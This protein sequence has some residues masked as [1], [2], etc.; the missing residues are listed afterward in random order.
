MDGCSLRWL[1]RGLTGLLITAVLATAVAVSPAAAEADGKSGLASS[2]DDGSVLPL[3]A[4]G[5]ALLGFLGPLPTG[6]AADDLAKAV[7]AAS[8]STERNPFGLLVRF[9]ESATAVEVAEVLGAVGGSLI[10][11]SLDGAGLYLVETLRD[12]DA[13]LVLLG[14]SPVVKWAGPDA[15]V[16][17]AD[18]PSDPRL[19]ELWGLT[20]ANGI[21]APG[22]W[23]HSLGDSS[24]VVAVIDTGVDLDHPDLEANIWTNPGE[25][26]GNGI[27]DDGNGYIDDLHGW[28]FVNDDADPN[29]DNNHGT[30]VAGTIAGVANDVG[31]VGVAPGV[32][33]MALKFLSASGGGY[34]SDAVSALAY[35]IANGASISNNSWGGGGSSGAM[36]GMIDQ[37]AAADHLFVAA[38]GNDGSDNDTWPTYPASYPQDIVLTVASTQIDGNRSSFSN[39]GEIGVD[40]AAPGSAILSSVFGGGYATFSG[41]SMATPHVVGVAALMR[42]V[43]PDLTA[44]QVKERLIDSSTW[45]DALSTVSGS[46]GRVDAAAAVGA[47]VAAAP[48]VSI[49][50]PVGAVAEG[51]P[52]TLVATAIGSDGADVSA[53]IA[54][55]DSAGT[56]LATG[57]IFQWTPQVAGVQRLRAAVTLA[58]LTGLDAV[59]IDVQEVQRGIT[60]VSPNGGETFA[61]GDEVEISWTSEGPVGGVDVSIERRAQVMGEYTGD[62]ALPILDHQTLDVELEVTD[63]GEVGTV[64]LGIRLNHTYDA[65]LQI[66]LVHPD[67]TTVSLASGVGSWRNDFGEGAADCSGTLTVF[68]DDADTAIDSG[69]APFAGRHRPTDA[70][71]AFAGKSALGTW[72]LRIHDQ[73]SWDQGELYCADLSISSAVATVATGVDPS[74]G[75]ATWIVPEGGIEGPLMASVVAGGLSDRSDAWF[76]AAAPPTTT[77]PPCSSPTTTTTSTSTTAPPESTTTSTTTSSSTTVPPESTTTSTTSTSTTAPPES[78]TTTS[79]T[80]T[81]TTAP[82]E[83]TTTTSTTTVPPC[84]T[85]TT[86][87]PPTTTTTAPPE[88]TSTTTTTTTT[89]STTTTTTLPTTTTTAPPSLEIK[90]PNGGE[91]FARGEQVLIDWSATNVGGDVE[92]LVRRAG[93]RE[94]ESP[95]AAALPI[96][97]F[98]TLVLS[99]EMVGEGPVTAIEVGLR[100]DHTYTADLEIRLVAPDGESVR[101]AFHNGGW[102]DDFGSGADDCSGTLTVFA[103]DAALSIEA[104]VAPFVGRHRP[105]ESMAALA[106]QSMAG[107]W[108]LEITDHWGWD[109]GSLYC[110]RLTVFGESTT[111]TDGVDAGIGSYVWT[112]PDGLVT[113]DFLVEV[114]GLLSDRSDGTFHIEG[115]APP[116]TTTTLPPTTTTTV[117][118]TTTTTVPPTTTLPPTTT[119]LPPTTTTTQP[120]TTDVVVSTGYTAEEF[121]GVANA[122]AIL[123]M[124]VA[125][126]QR[127]G[128]YVVSFLTAINPTPPEPLRPRPPVD[129]PQVLASV[130]TEEELPMLL[131]V[132][133]A[134]DLT[135]EEM[136]KFGAILLAFFVGLT[137]G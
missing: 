3:S 36:S 45:V 7:L 50:E 87:A 120:P 9:T 56:V 105:Y 112:S 134:W 96:E 135:P 136:Q 61:P 131:A 100:L 77:L 92:I 80:S 2:Y 123:G 54:W 132:S 94:E 19:D 115:A 110:A 5:E 108:H 98:E 28:D 90:A 40:V 116:T 124:D 62:G 113:G 111:V 122:A 121:A 15:V 8:T 70:L 91:S 106:G 126:F 64:E 52:V 84:S 4:H 101:L 104:G 67:G 63:S 75:A 128:V 114:I 25:I 103:D 13:A 78:T 60:L 58:G 51:S 18:L 117:P 127:T 82:P 55:T 38:A 79:T 23:A 48:V 97:D 81:S 37:A 119:T 24:V 53:T 129:G 86:T 21:D 16:R 43:A 11:P 93:L 47:S 6:L 99:F 35:A 30:H 1:V 73:W 109:Q 72:T 12:L 137:F 68:A 17:V 14:R 42:S 65:D 41:T 44:V 76:T 74:V 33:I 59:F 22:A 31:V 20:G 107:T 83:S 29:D 66:S 46:G 88:S 133:E 85:T 57:G 118:P 10:G 34:S 39:Y 125:E 26:P 95:G 89:T 102:R 49:T 27:D 71:S 32:R 69:T 130:W